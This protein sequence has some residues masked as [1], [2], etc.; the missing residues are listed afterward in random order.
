MRV[1]TWLGATLAYLSALVCFCLCAA[2]LG[3]LIAAALREDPIGALASSLVFLFFTL[4]FASHT[5][6]F[7]KIAQQ[8]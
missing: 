2:M 3:L 8:L 4:A 7:W 1:T 5:W 6:S